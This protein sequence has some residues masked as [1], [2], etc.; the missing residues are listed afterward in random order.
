MA[1]YEQFVVFRNPKHYTNPRYKV[2]QNKTYRKYSDESTAKACRVKTRNAPNV[3]KF[4]IGEHAAGLR[5]ILLG[6]I[7]L[8]TRRL[9]VLTR[10]DIGNIDEIFFALT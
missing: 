2:G 8:L 5:H 3:M 1:I 10:Q 4:V 6:N 9:T 7:P